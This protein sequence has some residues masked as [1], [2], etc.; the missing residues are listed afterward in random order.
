ME[1]RLQRRRTPEADPCSAGEKEWDW[2]HRSSS[3]DWSKED[4]ATGRP[5]PYLLPLSCKDPWRE[6]ELGWKAQ[7]SQTLAEGIKKGRF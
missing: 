2:Q 4:K 7:N 1:G 6:K 3:R 5:A